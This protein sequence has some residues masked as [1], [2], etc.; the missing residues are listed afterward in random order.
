MRY[1]MGKENITEYSYESWHIRYVGADVAKKIYN[2][3]MVL[4]EYLKKK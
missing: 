3:H 2:N 1:P 4:E